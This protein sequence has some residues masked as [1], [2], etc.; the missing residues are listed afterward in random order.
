MCHRS[1]NLI[2]IAIIMVPFLTIFNVYTC[3]HTQMQSMEKYA[4]SDVGGL[5]NQKVTERVSPIDFYA[6]L[7]YISFSTIAWCASVQR[8]V[9]I[10]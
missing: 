2:I 10:W 3:T 7:V 5:P 8:F 6:T 1:N 9:G 4:L